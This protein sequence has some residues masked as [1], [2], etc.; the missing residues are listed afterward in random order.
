MAKRTREPQQPPPSGPNDPPSGKG[1]AAPGD[2]RGT[3]GYGRP[4]H[5]SD[6]KASYGFGEIP[7]REP[8]VTDKKPE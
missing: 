1:E 2:Y 3:Y 6:P 4:A 8:D 7:P 5:G